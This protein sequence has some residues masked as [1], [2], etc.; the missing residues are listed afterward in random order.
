MLD[1]PV[2]WSSTY[3]MLER[4]ASLKKVRCPYLGIISLA[5]VM[6]LTFR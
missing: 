6:A 5:N 4:A 3:V 1:M 2:R